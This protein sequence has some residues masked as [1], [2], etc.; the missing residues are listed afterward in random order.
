MKKYISA[1]IALLVFYSG[2]QTYTIQ[3]KTPAILA[4]SGGGETKTL[5]FENTSEVDPIRKI[6][7]Y[8][9]R[10]EGEISSVSFTKVEYLACTK[11]EDTLLDAK[12]FSNKITFETQT[13][14]ARMQ[15]HSFINVVPIVKGA[16]GKLYKIKRFNL[17]VIKKETLNTTLARK[18]VISKN[19]VFSTGDWYKVS[20]N[21]TGVFKLDLNYIKSLGIPSTVNPHTLQTYGF[22]GILPERNAENEG[23][24]DIPEIPMSFVGNQD[25]KFDASEYFLVYLE[26]PDPIVCKGDVDQKNNLYS[27][28]SFFFITHSQKTGKRIG[29]K[30]LQ[31][32]YD[33]EYDYYDFIYRHEQDETNYI[34]SGRD[35]VGES[36]VANPILNFDIAVPEL[37]PNTEVFVTGKIQGSNDNATTC[38]ISFNGTAYNYTLY[39]RD[40]GL[41]F[42]RILVRSFDFNQVLSSE[43]IVGNINLNIKYSKATSIDKANLD[44]FQITGKAKL[45]FE[46]NYMN[47]RTIDAIGNNFSKY[48]LVTAKS[49]SQIWDVTNTGNIQKVPST[50]E[51]LGL[52]FIDSSS[53]YKEYVAVDPSSVFEAPDFIGKIANQN[54]LGS[55]IPDL[56]I[57]TYPGFNDAAERLA[58][59]R[60]LHD[61]YKV[62]VVSVDK[63]YN[64]FS[65]G[66]QDISGIRNLAKYL[67][68]QDPS[69]FKWL[70]LFGACSYDYKDRISN[71]TNFVPIYETINSSDLIL[72]YQSDDYYGLLD[73][74]E[75]NTLIGGMLDIGVGRLPVRNNEEANAVVDKLIHYS[76]SKRTFDKW[77]NSLSFVCDDGDGNLHLNSTEQLVNEVLKY[78]AAV[79]I[80]KLY[81]PLFAEVSTPIGQESPALSQRLLDEINRGTFLLNYSGH[82]REIGWAGENIITIE[83]I[84]NLNNIDKLFFLITA[85]CEFG[86]YDDPNNFSSIEQ[87]ILNPS[88]GAVATIGATRPVFA[89]SNLRVNTSMM[90]FLYEK[91]GGKYNT[92]GDI[93]RKSKNDG[94]SV[95]I[96]EN[97]KNYGLLCDPSLTLDYP[98]YNISID[99]IVD[100]NNVERD[101]LR[102]LSK[103]SIKGSVSDNGSTINNF[104]GTLTLTLYDKEVDKLTKYDPS[105]DYS[106][107]PTYIK[108]LIKVRESVIYQGNAVV[109]NGK[110]N[111]SLIVPKDISYKV[112]T[113]LMLAYAKNDSSD[114]DATGG[115][116]DFYIGDSDD[117]V[118]QDAIS[119]TVKL[120]LNDT[121]FQQGGIVPQNST[122]I[123]H[124][125]D[126]SGINL[127]R[128]SVGHEIVMT[129]DGDTKN[130]IILNDYYM[131][132]TNSFS[133]G[134][135]VFPLN[136]LKEGP[137]TISLKVWDAFNNST[138]QNLQF[139][140]SKDDI[141]I[142]VVDN[143]P[144]PYDD[145][146]LFSFSHN[147]P[148]EDL[149]MQIQIADIQG[150]IVR[151]LYSDI[152]AAS[153]VVS[154]VDWKT[155]INQSQHNISS[156]LYVYI[157]LLK[158]KYDGSTTSKAEKLVF[159]K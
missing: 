136:N 99:S 61:G 78:N 154:G 30:T 73:N 93:M 2:A 7:Y 38:A 156:G 122:F 103:V 106:Y 142:G 67:Y 72:S 48:S 71:N 80:N 94:A 19:S 127:S 130:S 43:D 101:T 124:I 10:L 62:L 5:D 44:Y 133:K 118:A 158:S 63:V 31:T 17:N 79:K 51:A 81:V 3:W 149:Y 8:V 146:G 35:W 104:N 56:L 37:V 52:S 97:V 47:F 128:S 85:T 109:K 55:E 83:T 66:R 143:I 113:G 33:L 29:S 15:V 153:T 22:G 4:I 129:I 157:M 49:N 42:N 117:N 137:H 116:Y 74:N 32:S 150:N 64:E 65:S 36:L 57:V 132:A 126:E 82:G 91:S 68:D 18:S 86:R 145:F 102:A 14:V 159:I 23:F 39:N 34:H 58:N 131:A 16:D 139:I 95:I 92:I 112:G 152:P 46:D 25:D 53:L 108:T 115:F 59:F 50:V 41:D 60:R 40:N 125:S 144:N 148:G 147:R 69:K 140:V 45:V 134:T 87:A 135:V 107:D 123:A 119:P 20:V 84:R 141:T 98:K 138:T 110:F 88:G 96:D 21:K 89:S 9:I 151:E 12:L 100:E 111:V 77:R 155:K 76:A 27:D 70:L 75:G 11:Q 114:L 90:R 121:T 54:I 13:S 1:F 6:G 26:G 24:Y 28:K 120:F 105:S